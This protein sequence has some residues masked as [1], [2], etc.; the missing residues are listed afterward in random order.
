[1]RY[2][3][4]ITM[5]ETVRKLQNKQSGFTAVELLIT[6][7]VAAIFLSAGYILYNVVVTRS[8]EARHQIEADSIATDYLQRYRSLVT[9]TCVASTPLNGVAVTGNDAASLASPTVTVTISCPIPALTSISKVT[10]RV[11]YKEGGS[12]ESVQHAAYATRS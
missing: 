11:D 2:T 1:M 12:N 3:E 10:V 7:F 5:N 9:D 8:S 6:L 4:Y